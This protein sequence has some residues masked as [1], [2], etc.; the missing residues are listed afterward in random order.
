ML[1]Y[2]Q[3][4][5]LLFFTTSL[6]YAVQSYSLS[7][8]ELLSPA[9]THPSPP[10]VLAV[11]PSSHI[12]LS[13][14]AF[15]PTIYL[16]FLNSSEAPLLLKP[17]SSSANVLAAAFHPERS[18]IFALAFGDGTLSVL[19][20]VYLL[21]GK[22]RSRRSGE[23][24]SV[25]KLHA[26]TSEARVS[27]EEHGPSF[28]GFDP[29][30]GVVSV[31]EHSASITSVAFV[32]GTE[33]TTISVGADGKC[34]LVEFGLRGPVVKSWDVGGA[35]TSLSVIRSCSEDPGFQLDGADSTDAYHKI[36]AAIGR[37]DGSVQ[38]FDLNGRPI[39]K[40][41]FDTQGPV[42]DVEFLETPE[43]IDSSAT[44]TKRPDIRSPGRTTTDQAAQPVPQSLKSAFANAYALAA[45]AD[46]RSISLLAKP[47]HSHHS[48]TDSSLS[49]PRPP[50]FTETK[51]QQKTSAPI[52]S[53]LNRHGQ[54]SEPPSPSVR[55]PP[56]IPPRPT[57]RKG[58][59]LAMRHAETA[60]VSA[61]APDHIGSPTP[62]TK[63]TTFLEIASPDRRALGGDAASFKSRDLAP[64]AEVPQ[65]IQPTTTASSSKGAGPSPQT[66]RRI[67]AIRARLGSRYQ[68]ITSQDASLSATTTTDASADTIID[69]EPASQKT[70]T[71]FPQRRPSP[72]KKQR[73]AYALTTTATKRQVPMEAQ[74]I[75]SDDTIIID[76]QPPSST[77]NILEDPLALME[78]DGKLPGARKSSA[79]KRKASS[80]VSPLEN[81][82][83]NPSLRTRSLSKGTLKARQVSRRSE[84]GMKQAVV[85]EDMQAA[86]K[87][88]GEDALV[89]DL[90][91]MQAFLKQEIA[92]FDKMVE[93]QLE[94]QREWFMGF[95]EERQ[96][97]GRK[98]EEENG[99]LRERL[100]RER[101][102][103]DR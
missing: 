27:S 101:K 100:S 38:I 103:A 8:A 72:L 86:G 31:G 89:I 75:A 77:F 12:L 34:C 58:G 66:A 19:N 35:S 15:P 4:P 79:L 25:A 28:R 47:S 93:R 63:S 48:S 60:V 3:D 87:R 67:S 52:S 42:L 29:A 44:K 57:P 24:S 11:S 14:S 23:I 54:Q 55:P 76:W 1:M 82:S 7:R 56:K 94:R 33:C 39:V 59:K 65:L 97:W 22:G 21:R 50:T 71:V 68:S 45:S 40:C 37:R 84:Q 70:F 96:E 69:W 43:N 73:S 81:G 2:L 91:A 20:A 32:P 83:L 74:S 10:T 9:H 80:V 13:S 102:R 46:A 78:G 6:Q 62:H 95:M 92:A 64:S 90:E 53:D 16:Q 41:S 17:D 51:L 98:L 26:V 36:L 99:L 5:E 85:G 49:F 30:T 61:T 18:T 88:E